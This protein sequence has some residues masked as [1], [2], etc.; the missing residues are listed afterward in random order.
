LKFDIESLS[1]VV[2]ITFEKG[3]YIFGLDLG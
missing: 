2:S 3:F 1:C